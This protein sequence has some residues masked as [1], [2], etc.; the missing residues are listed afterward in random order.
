VI[1]NRVWQRYFGQGIVEPVDDWETATPSH[2]E[3]L[4]FLAGELVT[5][6][7]DL[8][9]VARLI[10]NS[11]A[12][13]RK[14]VSTIP[15]R[16]AMP[17]ASIPSGEDRG[18][19]GGHGIESEATQT[20]IR[21]FA[22]PVRRRMTGEHLVDSLF[23]AGGKRFGSEEM[24]MDVDGRRPV[25]DFYN[26]GTPAHSW[27]FASLSNERDR[28]ALAM[29]KAQSITDTLTAFGWRESRQSPQ[30]VRDHAPNV[31]QPAALANGILGNGR[32]TRLSDDNAITALALEDRSLTDLIHTVFLRVLSRPPTE[33]E[34]INFTELLRPDYA[35]RRL[36]PGNSQA[37]KAG[38]PPRA[39]SWANHLNPD[40]TKI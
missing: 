14:V 34:T 37:R 25:K 8:K 28:P 24:N 29:P 40:A 17:S 21:L 7:Y 31:L 6:D 20:G 18:T 23:A 32:V 12:Y 30:T 39:V 1:V 9:H 33:R 26:L 16:P 38:A 22:S 19:S 36:Q 15:D 5:H 11:Q 4:D 13:Q 3:L 35:Q 2:P 27:E 10:L